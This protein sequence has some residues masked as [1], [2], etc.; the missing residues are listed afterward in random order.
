MTI[1]KERDN[2]IYG[3]DK[4]F[5]GVVDCVLN[6]WDSRD[7]CCCNFRDFNVCEDEQRMVV[8]VKLKKCKKATELHNVLGWWKHNGDL[9]I[10]TRDK[11]GPAAIVYAIEDVEEFSG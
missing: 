1:L 4:Y 5:V 2:G 7:A 10:N 11:N 6:C 8:T 9:I 3:F